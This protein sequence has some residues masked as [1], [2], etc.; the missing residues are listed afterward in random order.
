MAVTELGDYYY[1]I[2]QDFKNTMKLANIALSQIINDNPES[3]LREILIKAGITSFDYDNN[4]TDFNTK[5]STLYSDADEREAVLKSILHEIALIN[6]DTTQL[7][8]N[9]ILLI[10]KV[11]F[12]LININNAN[13]LDTYFDLTLEKK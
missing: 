2:Y 12:K 6:K 9:D 11:E 7:K 5:L 3:T 8:E 13:M 4:F 1:G 10:K